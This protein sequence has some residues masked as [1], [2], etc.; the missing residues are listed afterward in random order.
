MRRA[1]SE[2]KEILKREEVL[3]LEASER[4]LDL[5]RLETRER[6]VAMAEDPVNTCKA[7]NQEEVDRRAAKA[8]ADLANE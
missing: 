3:M 1:P 7:K 2:E 6:H 4:S 8:R 5:E